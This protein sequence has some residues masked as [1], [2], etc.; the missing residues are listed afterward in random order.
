YAYRI[1]NRSKWLLKQVLK[2]TVFIMII[3][4]IKLSSYMIINTYEIEYLMFIKGLLFITVYIISIVLLGFLL[5][6]YK[7][8]DTMINIVLLGYVIC[9]VIAI[10][11]VDVQGL[12]FMQDISIINFVVLMGLCVMLY[13]LNVYKLNRFE[14]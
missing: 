10:L 2:I 6:Q 3:V 4:S 9:N 13:G 5:Y 12:I 8:D 11:I 14:D 7:R 1:E